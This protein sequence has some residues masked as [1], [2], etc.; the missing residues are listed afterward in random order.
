MSDAIFQRKYDQLNEKQKEAVDTIDGP[1]MV[2]AGPGTGKTTI[3]TLRIANIL[4]KTDTPANAILALTFTEAGVRAMRVKLRDSIGDRAYDVHIH[5]FYGF[6][7]WVI[8]TYGDHFIH[9]RDAVQMTEVDTESMLRSILEQGDFADLRPLGSPDYYVPSI[10]SAIGEMKKEAVSPEMVKSFAREEETRIQ[11]DEASLST[12]GATK[13]MLKAEAKKDIE[14]CHKTVLFADIYSLYEEEKRKQGVIDFDDLIVELLLAMRNDELLLRLIQEQ[15]LYV[16]VDEHQDTNDSQNLVLNMLADFF[17]NPNL[18]IV[19]DEKQAIYR[20]QGASVENFLRLK[21]LYATMKIIELSDNYRSHQTILDAGFSMIGNNYTEDMDTVFHSPLVAKSQAPHGPIEIVSGSSD[22]VI[23]GSMVRRLADLCG[24]ES[25]TSCAIIVRTN[26]DVERIHMLME[27]AGLSALAEKSIDVLSHTLG[28]L[29]LSLLRAVTDP[30]QLEDLAKVVAAGL[31]KLSFTQSAL[32]IREIRSGHL[33][34]VERVIP[35]LTHLR[36]ALPTMGALEF[37]VRLGEESGFVTFAAQSPE[38][39]EVWRGLISLAESIAKGNVSGGPLAMIEKL[40][41]YAES[42]KKVFTKIKVG[43][44]DARIHIMT[45]HKSKGLEFDYV[46][47]PYATE[48]AWMKKSSGSHFVLPHVRTNDDGERDTRRLFYVALTRARKHVV[49]LYGENSAD[50]KACSPLRF[51]Q[52]FDEKSIVHEKADETKVNV[53]TGV[54]REAREKALSSERVEYTKRILLEKGLSV[55][56]LNHFMVCPNT[57]FFQSILKLPQAPNPNSEKGNAMHV[58]LAH[59]WQKRVTSVQEITDI[60]VASI[61]AYMRGSLLARHDT[62]A[63]LEKLLKDAPVVAEALLP[64]FASSGDIYEE[65]WSESVFS[66]QNK[67]IHVAVTIHGKLDAILDRGSEALVFDY[68]TK[69]AMTTQ[70]I[71]GETKNSDGGYFRQLVFYKMLLLRDARF[72]EKD[73]IPSL[74]FVSPD[75]KGRCPTASISITAD[76]IRTLEEEIQALINSVW[77]GTFLDTTCDDTDCAWCR[78]QKLVGG[79][80]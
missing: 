80:S 50:G 73:I 27:N 31:F 62:E 46:F 20:F 18:F 66:S 35:A 33:E 37:L 38:G 58:A 45:A 5:T 12:R 30:S 19:G 47:I 49:V 4:K 36:R 54:S 57:F 8:A 77:S 76:D 65:T 3:L 24:S 41:T 7:S 78:L 13:G 9:L 2:I 28:A 34:A 68:K 10:L 59:V 23:E 79:S 32:L 43:A 42:K 21:K 74:V 17:E 40:F 67:D 53:A 48:E 22:E 44:E 14:K 72:K 56:A 55:T 75:E 25:T 51:I 52:E 61:R 70:A 29:Y 63:V 11:G 1:A 71:K 16:L 60:L 15:F 39:T 64:H 69:K 26:R 6:A